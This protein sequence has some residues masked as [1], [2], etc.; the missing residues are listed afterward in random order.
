MAK[1]K[2]IVRRGAISNIASCLVLV[3]KR[4]AYNLLTVK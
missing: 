4:N 3:D 2:P 1:H